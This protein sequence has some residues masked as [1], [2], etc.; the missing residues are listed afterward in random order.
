[1]GSKP[2][3]DDPVRAAKSLHD[4]LQ[5]LSAATGRCC[6]SKLTTAILTPAPILQS[7]DNATASPVSL[8][9]RQTP[10]TAVAAVA[11]A[12]E[13]LVGGGD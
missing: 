1:M 13:T 2:I 7:G 4:A 3:G 12:A 11:T 10:T 5:K 9:P 8:Q 6:C